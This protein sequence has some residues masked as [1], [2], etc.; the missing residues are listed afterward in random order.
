MKGSPFAVAVMVWCVSESQLPRLLS[1]AGQL[2]RSLGEE[3]TPI[4]RGRTTKARARTS[5]TVP[6]TKWNQSLCDAS[7][8]LFPSPT[9]PTE[10]GREATQSNPHFPSHRSTYSQLT[11]ILPPRPLPPLHP[12]TKLPQHTRRPL[13]IPHLKIHLP[14]EPC[15][16][17][18]TIKQTLHKRPILL[19]QRATHPVAHQRAHLP[20]LNTA[21]GCFRC[22][23]LRFVQRDGQSDV[24]HR[25][26]R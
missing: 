10:K 21:P 9:S 25:A 14:T 1:D 17:N 7:R 8:L 20:R 16:P 11:P 15:G 22:S 19:H 2:G 5:L 12:L 6:K 4:L 24:H 13:E 26:L 23:S 18:P 3:Y